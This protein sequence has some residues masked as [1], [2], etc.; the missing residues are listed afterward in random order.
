MPKIGRNAPCPCNSGQKFKR[1]CG[2]TMQS[3]TSAPSAEAFRLMQM[4]MAHHDATEHRRRLM[5]GLG[6]PIISVEHQGYRLVAVSSELHWSQHWRTFHDFLFA[7]IGRVLTPDWGNAELKKD[8][9]ER[10]PLLQWYQKLCEFQKLHTV[11]RNGIYTGEMTGSMKLYLELAYDLYLCAHNAKLVPLLVKR[12]KNPQTFEG[13]LYETFVLGSFVKAGFGIEMEE[14][15]DS[16]RAHCEFVATHRDTGRKFSVEAKAVTSESKRAGITSEP[17]RIREKIYKALAKD[18]AHERIIC[19]ELN[20]AQTFSAENVPDWVPLVDADVVD[21]EKTLT[22][23]NAPAPPAYILVTNR[24]HLHNLD[25]PAEPEVMF[26]CGFKIDDFAPRVPL[27]LLTLV[28]ARERHIELHW[29]MQAME[30][31]AQIPSTFDDKTPEEAFHAAELTSRLRIGEV[32]PFHDGRGKVVT[33]VVVDAMVD[34]GQRKAIYAFNLASGESVIVQQ[35]LG[36]A[37]IAA[38]T[39]SPDTYFGVVKPIRKPITKALD[40]FDFVYESCR[41]TPR[42]RLLQL[43]FTWPDPAA[44]EKLSQEELARRYGVA[45][46]ESFIMHMR[47]PQVPPSREQHQHG[48]GNSGAKTVS[49]EQR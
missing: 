3:S 45:L 49:G 30:K 1:C 2:F 43:M 26:A 18:L 42:E 25:A 16:T 10:H 41:N 35:E 23:S 20:R 5:Q 44:R 38:Y 40:T 19:V 47:K 33:G 32:H 11:Q 15:D 36:A 37:D 6:R 17:P 34:I 9:A 46:A 27:P 29:L 22:I 13:A 24:T 7:Y 31:H 8:L 28:E 39:A 14:E 12:L 48:M 21:A 4:Q